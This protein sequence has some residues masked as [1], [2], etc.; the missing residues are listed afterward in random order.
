MKFWDPL[1]RVAAAVADWWSPKL[2]VRT[3]L[4]LTIVGLIAI[5]YGPFSGEPL[6]VYEM[7]AVALVL[8]GLGVLVTAVLA[9][10]QD[11]NTSEEDLAPSSNDGSE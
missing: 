7:S 5:P 8:G 1:D 6:M 9:L 10:K 4:L 3:G 11:P 2:Q